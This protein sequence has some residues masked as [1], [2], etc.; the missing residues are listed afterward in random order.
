M[1]VRN[2]YEFS[3]NGR[4]GENI[5]ANRSKS[6]AEHELLRYF[7]NIPVFVVK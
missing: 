1:I 5:V 3:P 6:V 7:G 2:G 4:N